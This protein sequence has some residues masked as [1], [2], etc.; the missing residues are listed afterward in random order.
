MVVVGGAMAAE[1]DKL[2]TKAVV[3]CAMDRSYRSNVL[4]MAYTLSHQL[5]QRDTAVRAGHVD[6]SRATYTIQPWREVT[7]PADWNYYVKIFIENLPMH[8]WLE[9]GVRQMR[10]PS[11]LQKSKFAFFL[12][13]QT[14]RSKSTPGSL[15]AVQL[16]SPP[17]GAEVELLVHLDQYNDWSPMPDRTP[18]SGVSGL[19][20]SVSTASTQQA[21]PRLKRFIWNR[22]VP[23]G[24]PPVHGR[25]QD[26]CRQPPKAHRRGDS[27]DDD[28]C[29]QRSDPRHNNFSIRGR[30]VEY[31]PFR[32]S[33]ACQ[34][35]RS[36]CGAGTKRHAPALADGNQSHRGRSDERSPPRDRRR[37]EQRRDAEDWDHRRS[38][39]PRTP[40]RTWSPTPP[41][42]NTRLENRE[43]F[44][45][46]ETTTTSGLPP[47]TMP[48]AGASTTPPHSGLLFEDLAPA[49]LVQFDS[50]LSRRNA[51]PMLLEL[52]PTASD[53]IATPLLFSPAASPTYAPVSEAW[54]GSTAMASGSGTSLEVQGLG[55][56]GHNQGPAPHQ[57]VGPQQGPVPDAEASAE[58]TQDFIDN[59][60]KDAPPVAATMALRPAQPSRSPRPRVRSVS[61]EPSRRS[62]RQAKQKSVV[63][64]P[65]RAT[66]RLIRQ[67]D[68]AGTDEAIGDEALKR[69]MA[70]YKS[71][72]PRKAIATIWAMTRLA[73][74]NITKAAAALAEDEL[75]AQTVEA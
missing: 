50:F 7:R 12:P 41:A 23:D 2:R 11:R 28:H 17:E 21:Q 57:A 14:G 34:H 56:V 3:L 40:R 48:V 63:P 60:F 30:P 18:S 15:E 37:D 66:H 69:Y 38:R 24:R 22:G 42:D 33:G 75:V 31:P 29:D 43:G 26:S 1:Q 70:M 53:C 54:Q 10:N 55:L 58:T 13:T 49:E 19:P 62:I 25:Q 72:L 52:V 6:I 68:L 45:G 8:G 36:P 61:A 67:L 35:S 74:G 4:E 44:P 59:M 47:Q 65:M 5:Q 32:S 39:S 71:P 9:E 64:V 51:D 20:S 27:H 16:H 73:N 46:K